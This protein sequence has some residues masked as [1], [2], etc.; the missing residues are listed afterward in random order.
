MSLELTLGTV[1]R[2][3]AL[4][5]PGTL[6]LWPAHEDDDVSELQIS[7]LDVA[8]LVHYWLTNTDITDDND[9]R[10]KLIEVIK[11]AELVPGYNPGAQ[12]LRVNASFSG[13]GNG[14]A[15]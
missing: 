3:V 11:R 7:Q 2:V 5:T 13:D 15:G 4:A 10:L 8:Y 14:R 12:R 9:V 6:A 1:P